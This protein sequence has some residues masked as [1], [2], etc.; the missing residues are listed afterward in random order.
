MSGANGSSRGERS[1][2]KSIPSPQPGA[3]FPGMAHKRTAS[4]NPRPLS[5]TTEERRHE[6]RRV[7]ERTYEAHIERVRAVSPEKPQRR[8]VPAEKRAPE[9]R[10]QKSTTELRP[11]EPVPEA[12]QGM[13]QSVPH[14]TGTV[15][16]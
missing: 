3:Q 6:E 12:P 14:A 8:S 13:E 1:D 7:T 4:G 9:V 10:R 15:M 11:K 16:D 2:A 5:R